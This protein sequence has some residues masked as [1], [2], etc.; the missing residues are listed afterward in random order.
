MREAPIRRLSHLSRDEVRAYIL[1]DNKLAENAGWDREILAIEMQALIDLD[2]DVEQLGF[3]T[4]EIDLTIA[5]E[6]SGAEGPD[7]VLD[8]IE[9]VVAGPAVTRPGDLWQLGPHRLLCGD[10]RSK[11]DVARVCDGK[12]AALLFTDPPYNVPIE[13]HVTGLGRTKHRE[14]LVASGEMDQA[15]FTAFLRQ[16]L[17]AAASGL[18]DGAI[19]YVCMDWRHM[20]S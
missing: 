20:T 16:S 1:A 8:V 11:E 6:A 10:A 9:P 14:F 18:K 4:T 19:A 3:S 5:G 17:E 7:P 2:F 12:P 13:G 15:S